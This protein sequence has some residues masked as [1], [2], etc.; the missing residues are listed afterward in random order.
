MNWQEW[1]KKLLS[2]QELAQWA[3]GVE[4]RLGRHVLNY[5]SILLERDLLGKGFRLLEWS[6]ERVG[7]TLSE[8]SRSVGSFVTLSEF[9]IRT[10]LG[11]HLPLAENQLTIPGAVLEL[12]ER[13]QSVAS[14]KMELSSDE[15]EAWIGS[16]QQSQG[17][18]REVVVR[19]WNESEQR[20]GEIRLSC[21]LELRMA[22]PS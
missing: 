6:D 3:E 5:A 11:R 10:L 7:L 4:P 18:T 2:P 22:L 14:L 15:R 13:A 9:M 21:R 8:R 17:A 19:L 1:K 12:S 16:S 20:V